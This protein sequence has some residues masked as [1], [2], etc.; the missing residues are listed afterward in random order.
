MW[1]AE[2]RLDAILDSCSNSIP[3]L[4]SGLRAYICFVDQCARWPFAHT[5]F[6]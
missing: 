6:V 5:V 1:V 4:K 2:A 3:S